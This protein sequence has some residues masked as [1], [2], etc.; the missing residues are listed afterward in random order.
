MKLDFVVK[1]AFAVAALVASGTYAYNTF[2]DDTE[3]VHAQDTTGRGTD[4]WVVT[5]FGTTR[6]GGYI[7]VTKYVDNPYDEG[8]RQTITIYELKR[9]GTGDAQFH[10][11]G[12]RCIDYDA[13]PDLIK[14]EPIKGFTPND[15]KEAIA[16]GAKKRRR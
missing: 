2:V 11:V 5:P 14:F 13:G 10:L 16:K 1:A 12:S 3:T 4:G 15:L 6:D 9:T 8:K 7:A